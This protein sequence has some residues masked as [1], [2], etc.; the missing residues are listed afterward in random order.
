MV[1]TGNVTTITS[2][3]TNDSGTMLRGRVVVTNFPR[4]TGYDATRPGTVVAEGWTAISADGATAAV[5]GEV[6][7]TEV[8]ADAPARLGGVVEIDEDGIVVHSEIEFECD[9]T[10]LCTI[11][12]ESWFE[13]SDLGAATVTG[14]FRFGGERTGEITATGE[15]TLVIDVPASSGSCTTYRVAGG[16]PQE[17]CTSSS[18]GRAAPQQSWHSVFDAR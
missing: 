11:V 17:L 16:P 12:D 14:T 7:R 10:S 6:Q 1:T 2:D 13:V 8:S 18:S 9:E 4:H 5:S 3:C 15:D